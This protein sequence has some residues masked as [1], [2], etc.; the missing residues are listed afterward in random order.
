M[1][2]YIARVSQW[3]GGQGEYFTR[4]NDFYLPLLRL[5]IDPEIYTVYG[6]VCVCVLADGSW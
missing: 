2:G 4:S 1:A 6:F 5:G 3:G